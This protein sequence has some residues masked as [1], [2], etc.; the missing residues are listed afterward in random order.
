M[1]LPKYLLN[2]DEDFGFLRARVGSAQHHK[3]TTYI[4]FIDFTGNNIK[5]LNLSVKD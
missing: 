2:R 5:L 1:L 3:L 4:K